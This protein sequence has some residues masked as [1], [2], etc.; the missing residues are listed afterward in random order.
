MVPRGNPGESLGEQGRGL[1]KVGTPV[2]G[3]RVMYSYNW[4]D[5]GEESLL[6]EGIFPWSR[7]TGNESARGG[8]ECPASPG[9]LLSLAMYTAEGTGV[10]SVHHILLHPVTRT[11]AE[12]WRRSGIPALINVDSP[13]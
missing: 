11:S 3:G 7:D 1:A 9:G 2:Q 6:N 13:N 8:W 12:N 10:F 5:M 4:R